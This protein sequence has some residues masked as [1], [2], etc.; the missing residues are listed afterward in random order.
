MRAREIPSRRAISARDAIL[1]VSSSW[2]QVSARSERTAGWEVLL[3]PGRSNRVLTAVKSTITQLA[4]FLLVELLG[5]N[6]GPRGKRLGAY[7]LGVHRG[8]SECLP[9]HASCDLDHVDGLGICHRA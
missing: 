9:V 5:S 2:R 1:P 3:L 4:K 7:V 8:R 6:E